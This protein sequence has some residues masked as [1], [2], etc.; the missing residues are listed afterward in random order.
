MMRKLIIFCLAAGLTVSFAVAPASGQAMEDSFVIDLIGENMFLFGDGTGYNDYTGEMLTPWYYYPNTEWYNQWF[1]NAP[2]DEYRWKEIT[3]DIWLG[4][5]ASQ[6][7]IALNWSTMDYPESG[8]GGPPPLPWLFPP[9]VEEECIERL[10]IFDGPVYGEGRITDM[11]IIPDYNPEWVSIDVRA[12]G[13]APAH[14]E[15]IIKHECIPAPG[16]IVLGSIGIGLVGWLR[17]RRTL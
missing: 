9:L 8:P 11:L 12:Y 2:P 14:V 1:Y 17:R 4:G 10:V 6:V 7:T 13:A 5:S 15:G 3:Y 16:A